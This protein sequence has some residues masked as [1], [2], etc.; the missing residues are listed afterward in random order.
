MLTRP[1][2]FHDPSFYEV[3]VFLVSEQLLGIGELEGVTIYKILGDVFR[4][5]VHSY[6]GTS[7]LPKTNI[8][9][10]NR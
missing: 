8:A 4:N 7:T 10:E 9:D 1:G 3:F 5:F 2:L 6:V